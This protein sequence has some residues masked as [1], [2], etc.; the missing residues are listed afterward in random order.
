MQAELVERAGIDPGHI[1]ESAA[2][3]LPEH[4]VEAEDDHPE[5]L[6]GEPARLLRRKERLARTGA[7]GDRRT[8]LAGQRIEDSILALGQT[9]QLA[10]LLG[11]L[12]RERRPQ[13]EGV[14]EHLLERTDA[15]SGGGGGGGL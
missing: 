7:T 4:A 3:V 9:Q 6:R 2:E 12:D 13:L 1:G 15:V 14:C 11:Q 10:L 5:P 8:R